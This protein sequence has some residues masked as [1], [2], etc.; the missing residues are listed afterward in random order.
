M[1]DV[2]DKFC[3]AFAELDAEAMVECY[4]E[5]VVFEDPAFGTL[6]GE[7]AKNMWR[8]LCE[9]QK[10]KKFI[11]IHSDVEANTNSGS[12]RWEALY[13]FSRTNRNIRNKIKAEFKFR[14][15]KIIE[16]KDDFDLYKWSRQALGATCYLIGWSEF[17][18][19]KLQ[20]QTKGL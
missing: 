12:A 8:M 15:G 16:H 17:F 3:G 13:V 20:N 11:V 10:D 19:D 18:K 9:S 4:H 14:E 5:D 1:K 2:I 6:S 7:R